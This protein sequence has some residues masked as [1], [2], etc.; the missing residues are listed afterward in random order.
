MTL[1]SM[2]IVMPQVCA[3][4]IMALMEQHVVKVC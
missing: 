1:V 3:P 4:A 2:E